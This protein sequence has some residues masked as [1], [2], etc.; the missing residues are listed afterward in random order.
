MALLNSTIANEK[1]CDPRSDTRVYASEKASR[2]E[3]PFGFSNSLKST[4]LKMLVDVLAQ[5]RIR[6]AELS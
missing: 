2:V 1:Q 3:R 5:I 4:D 6:R